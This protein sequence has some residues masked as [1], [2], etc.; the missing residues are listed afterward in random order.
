MR[1]SIFKT[2]TTDYGLATFT[3]VF[4]SV[5]FLF[6]EGWSVSMPKVAFM[7][8]TPLFFLMKAPVAN[9][10]MLFG[11]LYLIVT[12]GMMLFQFANT[13]TSTFYYSALFLSTFNLY[14]SLV[15]FKEAFELDNFIKVVKGV[16]YAY[17][18]CLVLQQ[19]CMVVGMR[20]MPVI[21]LMHLNYY[22]TFSRLNSL[23]IEPSHAA[24][25]MT[26]FFYALLKLTEIKYDRRLSIL[27][28][29]SVHKS[30]IIAFL[31]T[32][33]FLGSG[34]AFVGLGILSLYFL[35]KQHAIWVLTCGFLLYMVVPFIHY[36]PLERAMAVF[37]ASLTGDTELVKHTDHSASARVN[38]ILDT[39]RYLDFS[40]SATWFGS[41]VDAASSSGKSI[42]SAIT[43]YGLI[44]YICKLIF[45]FSCCFSSFFSLEV[46]MFILLFGMDVG[47]VAYGYSMLM[48]FA[49]VKYFKNN[50]PD[51]ECIEEYD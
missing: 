7:A 1:L 50:P 45:I 6:V 5:Q 37:N 38:I 46:L 41:G 12:V 3:L 9:K 27:E 30:V 20:Y 2:L 48:L 51:Y 26:V 17:A 23:A 49:T 33:V 32:M 47:N 43:Y 10:A 14:Y 8:C 24:R 28:L 36:E 44:S 42:V 21:N 16:I 35:R 19:V 15:Y 31:Y 4:M 29:W 34:T 40:D 22:G 18:I 39:F 13:R 11:G 25:L